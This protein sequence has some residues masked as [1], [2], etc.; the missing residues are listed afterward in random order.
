[1][2]PFHVFHLQRSGTNGFVA[3]SHGALCSVILEALWQNPVKTIL[4]LLVALTANPSRSTANSYENLPRNIGSLDNSRQLNSPNSEEIFENSGFQDVFVAAAVSLSG[5]GSDKTAIIGIKHE[6]AT[7]EAL[8]HQC[9]NANDQKKPR[10][11]K[12]TQGE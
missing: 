6:G 7:E 12:V 11:A 8:C 9:E 3:I 4:D 2:P 10:K 1:M 5:L